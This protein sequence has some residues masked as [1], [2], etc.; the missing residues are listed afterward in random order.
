MT[1]K[2]FMIQ[3]P[4]GMQLLITEKGGKSHITIST[5]FRD[6]LWGNFCYKVQNK[7]DH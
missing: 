7:T 3:V 6:S 1:V 2:G 5:N 4:G